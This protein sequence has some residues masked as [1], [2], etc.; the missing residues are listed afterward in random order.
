MAPAVSRYAGALVPR[1]RSLLVLGLLLAGCGPPQI[2]FDDV[3]KERA[4]AL[5]S[6]F[7]NGTTELQF[8]YVEVLDDGRGYT[9]GLGFT[10][11]TGDAL[12]VVERYTDDQPNNP[13]AGFLPVLRQLATEESGDTTMLNGF[14]EA[15]AGAA[16]D[17]AFNR[18][19]L[20]VTDDDSYQPAIAHAQALALDSALGLM[21]LYDAV[22]M[23]GDGDDEDGV[24]ALIAR[25]Q[26]TAD[27]DRE[28]SFL[29]QL[30]AV[31]RADMLEP[32]DEETQQAWSEAVGRVDVLSDE[33]ADG[34]LAFDGP[35]EV[36]R[37]YDVVVP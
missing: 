19:Q 18:T 27:P 1:F 16:T 5:I 17:D 24:P 20:A 29:A 11:A 10:T 8:A 28:A 34:K 25:T 35:I 4:L 6:V 12:D 37:G 13:L 3:H 36:G 23:H 15:W 9:C 31:R 32:A 7:E 21:I 22:W 2:P 14:P 30:L 33:L 26:E